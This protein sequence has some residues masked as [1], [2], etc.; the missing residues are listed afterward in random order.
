MIGTPISASKQI[1]AI[2]RATLPEAVL[3][4]SGR[5]LYTPTGTLT[6][7]PPIY[8]L[9]LNPGEDAEGQDAHNKLTVRADLV[10]L[11]T[12]SI[13]DHAYLDERWKRHPP[14]EAPIQSRARAIFSII[15]G[16]DRVRGDALLRHTPISNFIL[17]RS[18]SEEALLKITNAKRLVLAQQC[19]PFHRAVIDAIGCQVVLTHAVGVARDMARDL[20]LGE[21]HQRPSGWGGTLNTLYAWQLTPNV[22]LLALP[23]LSRYAPDGKRRPALAAFFREFGPRL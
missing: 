4:A 9:G 21:G 5:V 23:N 22:R 13:K 15:C 19:W 14:G 7:N 6:G 18:S 16:N 17:Q 20:G 2:A 11:E 1:A 12:N 3:S 8:F 10:R